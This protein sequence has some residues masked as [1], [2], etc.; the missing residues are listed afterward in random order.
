VI[1]IFLVF[2]VLAAFN[3]IAG[4]ILGIIVPNG[5][6]GGFNLKLPTLLLTS[7]LS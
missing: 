4:N 5:E 2:V 7:Y 6:N 1:G 3:L